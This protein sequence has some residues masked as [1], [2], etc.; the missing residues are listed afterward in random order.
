MAAKAAEPGTAA[1]VE[2]CIAELH[3]A[4]Q[5]LREFARGIHPVLLTERGLEPALQALAAR[6]PV[7]VR[8]VAELDGRLPP[9]QEAALYYVAAEALT[10]V[11][12]HAQAAVTDVRIGRPDGWAELTVSDDGVGGAAVDG[13][14]GLRGLADRL[15]AL[16]GKI[17]IVS[18][19]GSGTTIRARV[20]VR[21]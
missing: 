3:T 7:P 18:V 10:N 1:A 2:R 12:K 20:P 9:A 8:V 4:L 5:E 11:A 21:G 13:G 17:S 16:G 19:P 6:S 14:T 15:D